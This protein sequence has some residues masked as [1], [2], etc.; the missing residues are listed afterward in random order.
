[1]KLCEVNYQGKT[2]M[3]YTHDDHIGKFHTQGVFYELKMLE[4][5]KSRNYKN[6]VIDAGANVGNHAVFMA[7]HCG[8][9]VIAIEP[10]PANFQ[11][12]KMNIDVNPL[13]DQAYI[14][15]Y[16]LSNK[17]CRMGV[18]E[19]TDNM[20]MCKLVPGKD[21]EVWTI[22]Y[23][24]MGNIDMIKVD[25]EG[26]EIL[27]LEGALNTIEKYKPDLFIEAQTTAQ[28][29]AIEEILYPYGYQMKQVFN[30]TP[31]YYYTVN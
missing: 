18:S 14:F 30:R 22:D 17:C 9:K 28:R 15:N 27:V 24:E 10:V 3:I 21:I 23:I 19:R 12:L 16:G 26:M 5:I 20:G 13:E 11:L 31:T 25:V 29:L 1:M 8:Y 2:S 4:F 6:W 7:H